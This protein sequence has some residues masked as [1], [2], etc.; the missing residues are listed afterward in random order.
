MKNLSH[1]LSEILGFHILTKGSRLV[2]DFLIGHYRHNVNKAFPFLLR[3]KVIEEFSKREDKLKDECKNIKKCP[4]C[5]CKMPQM[6]WVKDCEECVKDEPVK[7]NEIINPLK[8]KKIKSIILELSNEDNPAKPGESKAFNVFF[9]GGWE[10]ESFRASCGCT[11]VSI[12]DEYTLTGKIKNSQREGSSTKRI[13][14]Q[15][16]DGKRTLILLKNFVKI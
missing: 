4:G 16:K 8:D 10:I 5:G 1:S 6:L 14:V 15:H 12:K 2:S 7:V 11:D 3:K 9:K 13:T